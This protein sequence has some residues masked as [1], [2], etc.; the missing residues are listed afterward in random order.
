MPQAAT[1]PGC[2]C[3][4]H[5][6][7]ERIDMHPV[8]RAKA[9]GLVQYRCRDSL[10]RACMACQAAAQRGQ[11]ELTCEGQQTWQS[12]VHGLGVL[13][14]C[15]HTLPFELCSHGCGDH[16]IDHQ[17]I[18]LRSS[19][20]LSNTKLTWMY[21]LWLGLPLSQCTDGVHKRKSVRACMV[22]MFSRN[23]CPPCF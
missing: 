11:G 13:K 8:A 10:P 22:G 1:V 15:H 4:W 6:H 7:E 17:R 20:S 5:A 18:S 14:Q 21:M 16:R 2:S 3:W 12:S 19:P 23:A 9:P